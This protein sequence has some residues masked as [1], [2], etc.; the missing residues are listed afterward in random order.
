[1]LSNHI[2]LLR[3]MYMYWIITVHPISNN[4]NLKKNQA[5]LGFNH[6]KTIF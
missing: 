2:W 5:A 4:V 6:N 1:M 3:I